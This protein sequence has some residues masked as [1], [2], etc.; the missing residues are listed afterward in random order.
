MKLK[1]SG[2]TLLACLAFVGLF[3]WGYANNGNSAASVQGV[4][5][6]GAKSVLTTTDTFYDFGT[7]SMKNGDVSK[8][9]T[10]TNPT[11]ADILIR[12]LETS[13]MCTAALLVT[14]DGRILGPFGMAGMGGMTTTNEKIGSKESRTLRVIY[15]PNAHGPAGVGSIDRFVTLTDASGASLRFEIKAVVTP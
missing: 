15:N 5:T 4:A 14:P 3:I 12:G 9:F 7:I 11:N 2:I 13:C 6:V 8:D 1:T 10:I